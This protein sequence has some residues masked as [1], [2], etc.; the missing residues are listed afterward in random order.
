MISRLLKIIGL[1]CKRALQKRRYSA[2]E[3]CHFEEPTN[4]SHP[5]AMGRLRLRVAQAMGWRRLIE[6]RKLHIIFHKGATK[7]RSLLLQMTYK[8]K[9]SCESSPP[10]MRL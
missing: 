2:K 6:S 9:G 10:C 8:D 4:K 5:V 7:Y 1:F 3:T